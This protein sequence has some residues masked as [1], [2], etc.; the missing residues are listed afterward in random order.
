LLK[1]ILW[2]NKGGDYLTKLEELYKE[3]GKLMIQLEMTQNKA[4]QVKQQIA[5][6][7]NPQTRQEARQD[8]KKD[9]AK[10]PNE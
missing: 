7:L 9:N 5:Q 2:C 1:T 10:H 8:D 4:L 3:Y 6:E